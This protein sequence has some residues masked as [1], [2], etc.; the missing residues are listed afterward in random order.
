MITLTDIFVPAGTAI[1]VTL[2]VAAFLFAVGL[3][4]WLLV[5]TASRSYREWVAT[6][7]VSSARTLRGHRKVG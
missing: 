1:F 3:I 4:F 7:N 5:R 6:S 2:V